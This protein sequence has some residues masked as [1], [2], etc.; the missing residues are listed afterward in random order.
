LGALICTRTKPSCHACPIASNC[1]ANAQGWQT[2][3]PTAKPKR[4]RAQ[5][6]A[7]VA[8]IADSKD[9][10]LL[11]QRPAAG[12]W[13]GLWICPQFDDEE[14]CE[15]FVHSRVIDTSSLKKLPVIQHAFTHFD[16]QLHPYWVANA[17]PRDQVSEAAGYCWYDP[18][19]PAKI[20]LAKP[21]LDILKMIDSNSAVD[22]L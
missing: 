1:I 10:V 9:A 7:Y 17:T 3:L 8:V 22:T 14:S 6:V 2:L 4:V 13:G 11:Q 16:L 5:R 15:Q 19:H 12:I 21:V 20:G 18:R